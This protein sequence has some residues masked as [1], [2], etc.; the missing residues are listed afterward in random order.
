MIVI[1][2]HFILS[3]VFILLAPT[4]TSL[5]FGLFIILHHINTMTLAE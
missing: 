1:H 2:R 4:T 5:I 3:G